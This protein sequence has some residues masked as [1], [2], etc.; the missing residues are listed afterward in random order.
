MKLVSA[1]AEKGL[2]MREDSYLCEKYI[3][4]TGF[5]PLAEIVERICL[6][7]YLHEYTDY[8]ILR[9]GFLY[10]ESGLNMA[11]ISALARH[12][13]LENNPKPSIWPWLEVKVVDDDDVDSDSS[14]EGDL[15]ELLDLSLE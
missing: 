2:V 4:G 14:S 9:R 7:K 11:S 6:L 15:P 13:A 3:D 8:S 12:K 5:V 10:S 1:L